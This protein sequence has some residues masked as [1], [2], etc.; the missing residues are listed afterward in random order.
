[1][2]VAAIKS[3]IGDPSSLFRWP[4]TAISRNC[5]TFSLSPENR[6]SRGFQKKTRF[7]GC[8]PYGA[9]ASDMTFL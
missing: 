4:Q 3:H 9:Y 8:T 7:K 1:M 6:G 2:T 5:E